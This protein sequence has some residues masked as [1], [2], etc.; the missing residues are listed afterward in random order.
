MDRRRFL[1][2][3]LKASVAGCAAGVL[4]GAGRMAAAAEQPGAARRVYKGTPDGKIFE[5]RDGG[6]RWA[7]VADFG[8]QCP[9]LEIAQTEKVVRAKIGFREHSFWLSSADGQLWHTEE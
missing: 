2:S 3:G 9:V 7:R 4:P 5:S 1:M 8:K 6:Q